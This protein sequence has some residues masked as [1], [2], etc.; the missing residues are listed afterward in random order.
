MLYVFG[1]DQTGVLLSDLYF[2][3][4]NPAKGQEGPEHGVRLEVRELERGALK[5][6]IYSAQPIAAGRPIWRVDLL[7]SVDGRP[8]SFDRTHHHPEFT[9]GWDPS[10]RKFERELSAEPLKWLADRLDTLDGPLEELPEGDKKAL[11][12][13]A[14]EIVEA[15]GRLLERV[16]AGELG[17]APTDMPLKDAR[18]GWL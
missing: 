3:D 5:G 6:S 11:R 7:E 1:F 9:A 4:P 12:A 18:V 17:V 13:A 2:V 16:R 14:P 8:G 10:A 15:T